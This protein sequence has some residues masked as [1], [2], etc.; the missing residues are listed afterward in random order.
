[1]II[2]QIPKA[3]SPSLK[4]SI[5]GNIMDYKKVKKRVGRGISAGGG[6]TAGRGTKGQKSRSGY[7]LPKQFEGGQSNLSLRLPKIKGFKTNK[8]DI[9]L[10]SLDLLQKNFKTGET[11]SSQALFEKGLIKKNQTAKVLNNGKI[12]IY[13]NIENIQISKSAKSAIEANK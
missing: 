4:S 6:K 13:L 8:E 3:Q 9:K 10:I 12:N 2:N 11:L 1:M 5:L 7:N